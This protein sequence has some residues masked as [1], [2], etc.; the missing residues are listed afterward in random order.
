MSTSAPPPGMVLADD[1]IARPPWA[2]AHPLLR[3]Y[4]DH[5]WGVPLH[6]ER[7]LFELLSL[8][9]FQAGLSWSTILKKRTAFR[10]A[11]AGFE[12]ETVARFDDARTLQ[13]MQDA[14]I[15]RNR[16]KIEATVANARATIAMREEGGLERL[17]WSF[18]PTAGAAQAAARAAT[19]SPESTA[20]SKALRARGFKFVG[21]TTMHAFMQAAGVI[22]VHPSGRER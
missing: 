9:A 8:E 21:P 4:Y 12:P 11:F 18:E 16:R 3:D 13:L 15:V 2:A 7:A 1:G 14:G 20:L 5:E 6:E 10:A 22:D 19:V 17:V